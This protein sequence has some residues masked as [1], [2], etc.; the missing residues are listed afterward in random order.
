L[1]PQVGSRGKINL[2][3]FR[4]QT[5]PSNELP[6]ASVWPEIASKIECCS[7]L[8]AVAGIPVLPDSGEIAPSL[9]LY[10]QNP[11]QSWTRISQPALERSIRSPSANSQ[12]SRTGNLPRRSHVKCSTCLSM[13]NIS[14]VM[15]IL[16][17]KILCSFGWDIRGQVPMSRFMMRTSMRPFR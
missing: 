14:L 8:K 12:Q 4:I 15:T 11:E 13:S 7:V 9:W 1:D 16:P 5:T 3:F 10:Q 17:Q 6:H 2:R